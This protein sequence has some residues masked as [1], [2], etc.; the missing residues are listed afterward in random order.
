M[1]GRRAS[2]IADLHPRTE[3]DSIRL[4]NRPPF[5]GEP[6]YEA[7]ER[8]HVEKAPAAKLEMSGKRRRRRKA[9]R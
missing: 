5:K 8:L 9:P 2:T 7:Y 4:S 3:L 6:G 1:P